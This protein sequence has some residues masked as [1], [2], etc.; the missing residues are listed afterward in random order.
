MKLSGHI[1][2]CFSLSRP[3]LNLRSWNAAFQFF[4]IVVFFY[5][6]PCSVF[7]PL[8]CSCFYIPRGHVYQEQEETGTDLLGL[9]QLPPTPIPQG[10][11]SNA[12][13]L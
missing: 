10:K 7:S 1:D 3:H 13:S 5:H 8:P 11:W 9:L 2:S 4:V 6:F 12:G